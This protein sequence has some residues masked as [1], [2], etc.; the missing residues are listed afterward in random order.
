MSKE[1]DALLS[2][3]DKTM[4]IR[5]AARI[6][7][8][9]NAFF[10]AAERLRN[11]GICPHC[12][13]ILSAADAESLK[14]AA[15]L[16]MKI[17]ERAHDALDEISRKAMSPV[18]FYKAYVSLQNVEKL[19]GHITTERDLDAVYRSTNDRQAVLD[20]IR[21]GEGRL[22]ALPDMFCKLLCVKVY[23]FDPQ[24]ITA[25]G[26]CP[27]KLGS[28]G[29][30]FEWKCDWPGTLEEYIKERLGPDTGM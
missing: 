24:P 13:D 17:G 12:D 28:L 1:S 19:D 14:S 7:E 23:R 22:K 11:V 8:A 5:Q 30:F 29:P 15:V 20:A 18:G 21:F 16:G 27:S 3:Y 25:G 6:Q 4:R 26:G 2:A 9:A 10:Q